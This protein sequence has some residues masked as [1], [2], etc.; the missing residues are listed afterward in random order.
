M[1]QSGFT[2]IHSPSQA[3]KMETMKDIMYARI[4]LHNMIIKHEQH[5]YDDNFEHSS[6]YLENDMPPIP[7]YNVHHSDFKRYL[8][9]RAHMH[10][11]K[12]N[13]NLQ[14][15]LVEHIWTCFGHEENENENLF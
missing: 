11:K 15:D 12:I 7:I 13:Q 4:I 6:D 5:T 8:K 2:I 10:Q 3:W 14:T 1:L 9:R